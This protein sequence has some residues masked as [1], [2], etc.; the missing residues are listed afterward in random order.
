M[1]LDALLAPFLPL[2]AAAVTALVVAS[3]VRRDYLLLVATASAGLAAMCVVAIGLP[4]AELLYEPPAGAG[5]PWA[6]GG[7]LPRM[8]IFLSAI[9]GVLGAVLGLPI[10]AVVFA[11]RSPRS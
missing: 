5:G 3:L 10:A 7:S 11:V 9:Y 1:P 8:I 6:G 2:V 4:V